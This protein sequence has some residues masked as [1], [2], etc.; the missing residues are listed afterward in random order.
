MTK[1]GQFIQQ[2]PVCQKLREHR[3]AIKAHPFT[4]AAYS[5]MEVLNIDTIGPLEKDEDGNSF[6]IVIIY[7][8]TRWVELYGVKDTSAA[9]AANA[10]LQHI[11]RFGAP[12]TLRFDRGSQYVNNIIA[13]LTHAFRTDQQLTMAYSKEESS[14][15]ER[16]NKEV[17]RHLRAI[18]FDRR[19]QDK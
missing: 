9:E 17:L 12:G 14:I 8:F 1:G 16:A 13:E 6:I 10:L 19:V 11:G 2:C 18:I 15:V 5:A 7:C 3:L 4:T